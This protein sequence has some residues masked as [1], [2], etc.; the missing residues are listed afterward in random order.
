[1]FGV[2]YR[3]KYSKNSLV[4]NA[5]KEVFIGHFKFLMCSKYN[6]AYKTIEQFEEKLILILIL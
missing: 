6:N 2:V 5:N 3:V 1:M 4:S